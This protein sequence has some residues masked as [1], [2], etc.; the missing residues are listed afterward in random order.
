MGRLFYAYPPNIKIRSA[1]PDHLLH[2]EKAEPPHT[3]CTGQKPSKNKENNQMIKTYAGK[4]PGKP[5]VIKNSKTGDMSYLINK[6][7]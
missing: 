4:N 3:P 1:P 7:Y 5:V 2:L 6:N